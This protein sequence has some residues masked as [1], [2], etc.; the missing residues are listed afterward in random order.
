MS[1]LLVPRSTILV[2][3]PVRRSRWKRSD[4]SWR[5]R[6]VVSASRRSASWPTRSKIAFLRLSSKT[7]PKR[8]P[9]DAD[10]QRGLADRPQIG[11]EA[12]ERGPAR[13]PFAGFGFEDPHRP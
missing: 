3:A 7:P 10:L 4:R 6:K 8:A 5:W 11:K 1:M 9:D 2:T 12:A 13:L